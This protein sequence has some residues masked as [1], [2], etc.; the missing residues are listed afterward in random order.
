M[1]HGITLRLAGPADAAVIARLHLASYR[2][3]YRDIVAPGILAGFTLADRERRWRASLATPG[4][5]TYLAGGPGGPAGFAEIG[6][7]RDADQDPALTGELIALH[8]REAS[9]RQG[10]GTALHARAA[11]ELAARGF[12]AAT[13]WV[14][15]ANA[16]AR[17]FYAAAGWAPDG[18]SRLTPVQDA[19][20][21]E[22]RY[23]VMLRA[24]GAPEGAS[25]DL[26]AFCTADG[27]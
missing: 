7:C 22:V 16:R 5:V 25:H 18:T 3:A 23:R 24:D 15:T 12:S 10:I 27:I 6:A 8:V 1:P 26:G 20:I 14:L 19:R 13:L 11:G 9:W 21:P 2:A 17:A 4:R